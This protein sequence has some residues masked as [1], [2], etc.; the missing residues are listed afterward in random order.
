[1]EHIK[2]H[3][4]VQAGFTVYEDFFLYN[5]RVYTQNSNV[6][7]GGHA[8]SI[9][10][11]GV[12]NG[13]KYW[14]CKN[15]WGVGWGDAGFFK[16]RRGTNECGIED[17]ITGLRWNCPAGHSVNAEGKC[18]A[19]ACSDTQ[20]LENGVCY[21]CPMNGQST[22]DRTGCVLRSSNSPSRQIRWRSYNFDGTAKLNWI[23]GQG[24]LDGEFGA[25]IDTYQKHPWL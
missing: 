5:G 16:I 20:Y 8:I 22:A 1:M 14:L 13:V 24:K 6:R 21:S 7:K 19:G 17:Q 11:W 12:E 3:G 10:G 25:N 18:V 4:A 15:S 9:I 23:N 2:E